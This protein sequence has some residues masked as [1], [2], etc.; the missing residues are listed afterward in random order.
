VGQ[1]AQIK[2][3]L[4]HS[5]SPRWGSTLPWESEFPT[6]SELCRDQW[7]KGECCRSVSFRLFRVISW[8]KTLRDNSVRRSLTYDG[9]IRRAITMAAA[10]DALSDVTS[11]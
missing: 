8:L 10:T 11:P 1:S 7:Y 6:S 4:S 2:R 9:G 3:Y 5:P